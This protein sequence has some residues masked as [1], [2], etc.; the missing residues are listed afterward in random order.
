MVRLDDTLTVH[1]SRRPLELEP[2]TEANKS[3]HQSI[4]FLHVE[5]DDLALSKT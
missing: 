1:E 5:I 4:H 2:F 3:I